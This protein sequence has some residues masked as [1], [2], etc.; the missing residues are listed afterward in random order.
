MR[1]KV[2]KKMLLG[3]MQIHILIQAKK[4]PFFG[5]WM[6]E[7]LNS[8]GYQISPGTIYPLLAKMEESELL[9]KET[10]LENGKNRNYYSITTEGDG[11]LAIAKEKA[12][13]LFNELNEV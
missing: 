5:L 6:I 2:P 12:M 13:F 11:V 9:K 3:F 1:N 7:Q 8:Y 4:K 10:R